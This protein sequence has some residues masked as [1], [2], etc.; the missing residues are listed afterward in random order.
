M[1]KEFVVLVLLIDLMIRNFVHSQ[2]PFGG[3]IHAV[4]EFFVLD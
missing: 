1:I 3:I 4:H 2:R